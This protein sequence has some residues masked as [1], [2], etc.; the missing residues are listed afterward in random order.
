MFQVILTS[1]RDENAKIIL[2]GEHPSR[3]AAQISRNQWLKAL[4]RQNWEINRR[5]GVDTLD[6]LVLKIEE[7]R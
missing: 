5:P 7:Q 1:L 2:S 6:H 4:G 3:E